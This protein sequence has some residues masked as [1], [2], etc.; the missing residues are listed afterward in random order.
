MTPLRLYLNKVAFSGPDLDCWEALS[1]LLRTNTPWTLVSEW[2]PKP[3]IMSARSARRVSPQ[4]RLALTVAEQIG[5]G[6][7]S[8]TGW[9]F[10]SS[11]GEGE[12]LHV[13]LEALRTPDM[14]VQPLRFQNAVH[15]AAAGQWSV[16]AG[17]TGPMT[18]IAALDQTAGAGFLKAGLQISQE[19]R[20]VGLVLYDVPLP[21][22][23]NSKRPLGVPLGAGFCLS[24][25]AGP[26]TFSV[27]DITLCS[28]PPTAPQR[29]VSKA[30]QATGNPVA[31]VL[32]LLEL[33]SENAAGQVILGLHGG[34]ALCLDV[35]LA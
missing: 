16:A 10:A 29:S 7:G 15:N 19:D 35:S 32:P 11:V 28:E 24:P 2:D 6:L 8:D 25:Q 9:V 34:S 18:S 12:T 30:L 20:P 23:L 13:I 5:E 31:D 27:I 21:E 4:I 33:L 26:D 22:P 17:L 3:S 14:M 1:K